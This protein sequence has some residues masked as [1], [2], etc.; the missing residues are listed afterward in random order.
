MCAKR[1]LLLAVPQENLA[2]RIVKN[3]R[4]GVVVAP[5]DARGFIE[6]AHNLMQNRNLRDSMADKGR[7]YAET[8]FNIDRITDRFEEILSRLSA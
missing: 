6:N 3:S 5:D 7:K 2:A 1:P 8:H 4:A